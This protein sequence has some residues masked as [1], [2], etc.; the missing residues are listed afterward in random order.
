MRSLMRGGVLFCLAAAVAFFALSSPAMAEDNG[1]SFEARALYINPVEDDGDLSGLAHSTTVDFLDALV[2]ELSV[3]YRFNDRFTLGLSVA[4]ANFDMQFDID[5]AGQFDVGDSDMLMYQL[6]GW[7]DLTQWGNTGVR[8]GLMLGQVSFDDVNLSD[9]AVAESLRRVNMDIGT[10]Y[11]VG[12][13]FDTPIGD[14]GWYFS[15]NLRYLIGGPDLSVERYNDGVHSQVIGTGSAD[16]D[17]LMVSLGFG[18][19]Y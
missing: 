1:W 13:R 15:S 11:G 8:A 2:P 17:P 18:Y 4:I 7:F 3:A 14:N 10:I 16:F 5:T 19:E 6:E 9:A 12:V